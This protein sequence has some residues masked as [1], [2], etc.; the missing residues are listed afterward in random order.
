MAV[1]II[2]ESLFRPTIL[3]SHTELFLTLRRLQ[4]KPDYPVR[5][6]SAT[7]LL[8]KVTHDQNV[9]QCWKETLQE[10]TEKEKQGGIGWKRLSGLRISLSWKLYLSSQSF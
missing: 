2:F 4:K 5:V 7:D 6:W 9:R 10:H 1:I 3:P 8:K